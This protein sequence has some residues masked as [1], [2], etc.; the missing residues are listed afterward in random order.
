[1]SRTSCVIYDCCSD[2]LSRSTVTD[3]PDIPRDLARK[4]T[5]LQG[6]SAN[7]P[8]FL[9]WKGPWIP[10]GCGLNVTRTNTQIQEIHTHNH[11]LLLLNLAMGSLSVILREERKPLGHSCVCLSPIWYPA[12]R[13]EALEPEACLE[14][15]ARP[16]RTWYRD[17]ERGDAASLLHQANRLWQKKYRLCSVEW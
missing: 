7:S 1:M 9:I 5:G 13:R 17:T 15:T 12:T 14:A 16:W 10:A 8:P 2:V 6:E 11:L 4:P 3:I